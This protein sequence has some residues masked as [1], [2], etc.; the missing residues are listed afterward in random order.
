MLKISEKLLQNSN[1]PNQKHLWAGFTHGFSSSFLITRNKK[2]YIE[3]I[4]KSKKKKNMKKE[5]NEEGK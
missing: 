2:E 4:L 5:E 3:K 1:G